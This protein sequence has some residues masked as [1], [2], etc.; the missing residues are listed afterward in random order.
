MQ[1]Q[2]FKSLK[3]N[4]SWREKE[5]TSIMT[6]IDQVSDEDRCHENKEKEGKRRA[7]RRNIKRKS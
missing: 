5:I 3:I 1:L 6:E 4:S 2:Q 7:R